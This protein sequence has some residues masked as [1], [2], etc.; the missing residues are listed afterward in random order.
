MSKEISALSDQE[1]LEELKKG[2]SDTVGYLYKQ[3]YPMVAR[4]VLKNSGTENDA[5]DLFQ[6]VLIVVYKAIHKTDFSLTSKLSTYIHSIAKRMWLYKLRG[7]KDV[8]HMQGISIQLKENTRDVLEQK[9][10]Y[11]ERHLLV[12]E[13]LHQ[14]SEGC[15]KII[16]QFYF[17]KKRIK[18]IAREMDNSEAAV[19]V[20]KGRCLKKMIKMI[21]E[22]PRYLELLNE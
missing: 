10:Q 20:K 3:Y 16:L 18:E 1:I 2:S 4:F 21:R 5:R 6:E 13:M 17:Q 11:E 9:K 12:S 15:Q 8:Q 22:H 7:K 14:L 19:K